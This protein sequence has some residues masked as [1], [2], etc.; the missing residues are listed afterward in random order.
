MKSYELVFQ[1]RKKKSRKLWLIFSQSSC[2]S[3]KNVFFII[4]FV[5]CRFYLVMKWKC[6]LHPLSALKSKFHE[7]VFI[8]RKFQVKTV[9]FLYFEKW[10]LFFI[11]KSTCD[12]SYFVKNPFLKNLSVVLPLSLRNLSHETSDIFEFYKFHSYCYIAWEAA[13]RGVWYHLFGWVT[14]PYEYLV[15]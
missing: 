6:F 7:Y 3:K 15:I 10:R 5:F 1:P 11:I 2:P 8:L 13:I 12:Y 14:F 9:I 4:Y